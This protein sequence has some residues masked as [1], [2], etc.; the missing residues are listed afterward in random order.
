[1]RHEV[2][3]F[4]SEKCFPD[5]GHVCPMDRSEPSETEIC[6]SESD[7]QEWTYMPGAG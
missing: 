3:Y 1:M 2:I 6:P 4:L 7:C 5:E